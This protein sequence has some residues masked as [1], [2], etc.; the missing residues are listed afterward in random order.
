MK[1]EKW[2]VFCFNEVTSTNDVAK[3]F[4]QDLQTNFIVIADSQTKGRG[5]YG[6]KWESPPGKNL[7]STFSLK[8]SDKLPFQII[9]FLVSISVCETLSYLGITANCKWPNDI[10]VKASKIAGI[11]IEK[12]EARYYIGIGL[13]VLWPDS[14]IY[15][16]NNISRTS[17]V[18]ELNLSFDSKVIARKIADSFD[19][20]SMKDH[21][22]I[23]QKYRSFWIHKNKNVKVNFGGKWLHGKLVSVLK[24]GG[25]TVKLRS[26][27]NIEIFS[28][29]Q[30]NYDY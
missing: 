20:W 2:K 13:N 28:N 16:D 1:S 17:I 14:I 10:L 27:E 11:L 25:V 23:F 9:S 29:A 22:E 4:G 26:K 6:R 30:I 18:A 15:F 12:D 24:S 21:D 5:Q 8:L 3:K 7:L 19:L